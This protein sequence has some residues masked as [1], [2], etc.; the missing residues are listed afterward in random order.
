MYTNCRTSAPA[1]SSS[2]KCWAQLLIDG[3]PLL[4]FILFVQDGDVGLPEAIMGIEKVRIEFQSAALFLQER[5]DAGLC[6]L[7]VDLRLGS[8]SRDPA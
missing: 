8:A 1:S 5:V 3:K 6:Y 4:R 7:L 2:V